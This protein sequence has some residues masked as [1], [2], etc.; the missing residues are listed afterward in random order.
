MT[1]IHPDGRLVK[2]WWPEADEKGYNIW[3]HNPANILEGFPLDSAFYDLEA[4]YDGARN[5][6]PDRVVATAL[7]VLEAGLKKDMPK[8][9]RYVAFREMEAL[10]RQGYVVDMVW[11]RGTYVIP[12]LGPKTVEFLRRV[13]EH[14][15]PIDRRIAEKAKEVLALYVAQRL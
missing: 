5:V 4:D 11:A 9:R 7:D 10:F 12:S 6:P 14:W 13:I 3:A 15:A 1:I 8:L 2:E